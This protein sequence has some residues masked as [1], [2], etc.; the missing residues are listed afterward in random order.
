[1]KYPIL[2]AASLL[3]GLLLASCT[4]S[5]G[6]QTA[7]ANPPASSLSSED[8]SSEA[9]N[10]FAGGDGPEDTSSVC[11]T[12]GGPPTSPQFTPEEQAELLGSIRD[13]VK[14]YR[15]GEYPKP[16]VYY[17]DGLINAAPPTGAALPDDVEWE[18]LAI[19]ATGDEMAPYFVSLSLTDDYVMDFYCHPRAVHSVV[20]RDLREPVT[21]IP[22][23]QPSAAAWSEYRQNRLE[24]TVRFTNYSIGK[25]PAEN[26][27]SLRWDAA[28]KRLIV[29][30]D[31][32]VRQLDRGLEFDYFP[33]NGKATILAASG[34]PEWSGEE[35]AAIGTE[36]M[37]ALEALSGGSLRQ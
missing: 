6:S 30:F 19:A 21:E 31:W 33:E 27:G 3:C 37:S 26:T 23:T 13:T 8:T 28:A 9:E 2:L 25:V 7:S 32:K 4:Q 10:P 18:D 15:T 16:L 34:E 22:G 1:M 5:G 14:K 20:F 29:H 12:C 11:F 24:T 35:L 17:T 36:C